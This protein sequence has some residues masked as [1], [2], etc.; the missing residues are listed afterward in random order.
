M[1]EIFEF[2]AGHSLMLFSKNFLPPYCK[3]GKLGVIF[4]LFDDLCVITGIG[5]IGM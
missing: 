2:F 4:D 3:C 1:L 5:Y